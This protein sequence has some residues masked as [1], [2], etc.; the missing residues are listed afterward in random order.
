M[1]TL[2]IT[3]AALMA[4]ASTGCG[5]D[6]TASPLVTYVSRGQSDATPHLFT[7]NGTRRLPPPPRYPSRSRQAR[8]L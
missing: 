5:S 1:K 8:I 3:L 2:V 6:S 4:I 7:L